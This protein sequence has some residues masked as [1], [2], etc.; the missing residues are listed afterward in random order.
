MDGPLHD[1]LDSRENAFSRRFWLLSAILAL[2]GMLVFHQSYVTFIEPY[3]PRAYDQLALLQKLYGIYYGTLGDSAQSGFARLW[4]ALGQF[5]DMKGWL[6]PAVCTALALLFGPH[7]D[8]FV[9]GNYLFLVFACGVLLFVLRRRLGTSFAIAGLGL[10]LLS[11]SLY[12]GAGGLTDM[13]FDSAGLATFGIFFLA[14]WY[15]GVESGRKAF[16]LILLAYALTLLT[17]SIS[18]VYGLCSVCVYGL[19]CSAAWLLT[20][21][22]EWRTRWFATVRI[23]IALSSV[24]LVFYAI[25]FREIRDYY[26]QL[27][28]TAEDAIRLK[29]FGVGSREGLLLYYL[30][31]SWNHF[32]L[33]II[34]AVVL[35][36]AHLLVRQLT[37][38]SLR[39]RALED[40]A[41]W[42]AGQFGFPL[43]IG[44]SFLVGTVIPLS[45]YSPSPVVIA[46]LTIPL[47]VTLL[48]IV[49]AI[50]LPRKSRCT[51]L[52]TRFLH[53][54]VLTWGIGFFIVENMSHSIWPPVLLNWG[55]S[56]D[57][58][59]SQ[60]ATDYGDA[61]GTVA[62][63]TVNDG[64]HSGALQVLL[65]E[66]G[67]YD[68]APRMDANQITLFA[69]DMPDIAQRI[70]RAD[71]VV[72]NRDFAP[73]L[74][75][76]PSLVSLRDLQPEWQA[77][78]DRQ[79]VLRAVASFPSETFGYYSRPAALG[80]VT[81]PFGVAYDSPQ[82]RA[83]D[84]W[85]WINAN[86]AE[87][88]LRNFADTEI[89]VTLGFDAAP[90]PAVAGL[91]L[92]V[93]CDKAG[94]APQHLIPEGPPPWHLRV[95]LKLSPGLTTFRFRAAAEQPAFTG[96]PL[97]RIGKLH[98]IWS[99]PLPSSIHSEQ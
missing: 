29:E 35:I 43:L 6:L 88:S 16:G 21:R 4:T 66:T 14:L 74:P 81:G 70:A 11:N 13:R 87:I 20:R 25:H 5:M 8:V 3:Y 40:T 62:W 97:A 47:A 32:S 36:V 79:F 42:S 2:V 27:L 93:A 23:G 72:A 31:S 37:K 82:M 64:L 85:V 77:I 24:F 57:A 9:M 80:S 90:V 84:A 56:A 22:Q 91:T 18:G 68:V 10:V 76:Y 55:R 45:L 65:Y 49:S 67:R 51:V 19:I 39:P 96:Q 38:W 28:L 86:A 94:C 26:I 15:Y 30:A 60:L 53:A 69:L 46:A 75:P 63:L 83:R 52:A 95:L 48:T 50:R 58:L 1:K 61:G 92:T 54:G 99:D 17:R 73:T 78:L 12:F 59:L 89:P 71:A 41:V 44:A 98:L 7:R 34:A 33:M